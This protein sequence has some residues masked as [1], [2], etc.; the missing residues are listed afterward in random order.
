MRG[1]FCLPLCLLLACSQQQ[2]QTKEKL[3]DVKTPENYKAPDAA[4][5]EK[6][7]KDDPVAFLEHCVIR[8][9][10]KVKGYRVMFHKKERI[11]GKLKGDEEIEVAFRDKPHSVFM[12]WVKGAG[13]AV[14][15]L[16]VEG[17]NGGKMLIRPNGIGGRFV[18]VA[19]R[20][21]EGEDAK[22]SGRY[23]VKDFGFKNSTLRA[24]ASWKA[25]T[26]DKALDVEFVGVEKCKLAGNKECWVLKRKYKKP[27][28][29]GVVESTLYFDKETWLQ[30]GSVLRDKDGELIGEYF[31]KDIELN[32]KFKGKE[33][34]RDALLE[35]K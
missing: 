29:D 10:S 4:A 16:Y 22:Q 34:Q 14:S 21:P 8:Y 33:F 27:E 7:A 19:E 15:A 25:A 30:V 11:N 35:K 17:E 20:D 6:L 3:A 18:K 28:K 9:N 2:A 5:M 13:R 31:F 1:L 24:I 12:H 26:K 23:T 32:P